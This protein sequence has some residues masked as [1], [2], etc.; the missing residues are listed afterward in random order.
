MQLD[1]DE[2]LEKP[3]PIFVM[4]TTKPSGTIICTFQDSSGRN[5]KPLKVPKTWIPIKVSG[6]IPKELLKS[7]MDFRAHL[8]KG[9][10]T[11]IAAK[12]AM[13][14]LSQK[15]AQ[16]ELSRLN[17]SDFATGSKFATQS[18]KDL[19][20]AHNA[21]GEVAD[22]ESQNMKIE[23]EEEDLVMR[24]NPAVYDISTRFNAKGLDT[25]TALNELRCIQNDLKPEDC[26]YIIANMDGQVRQ[27]AKDH[28]ELIMNTEEVE[29]PSVRR[30]Q[31]NV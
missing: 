2:L 30:H 26:N 10:L 21:Q 3:E 23:N 19:M 25:K 20:A 18:A 24:I 8:D 28:L 29:A 5:S 31:Q 9:V 16:E 4:N 6:A 12:D 22:L 1:L 15:D 7:S 14:I 13:K 11:L 27:W 17:K